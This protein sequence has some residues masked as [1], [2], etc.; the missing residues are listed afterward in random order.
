MKSSLNVFL[1]NA[2]IHQV[3]IVFKS[4]VN[5][6]SRSHQ[7]KLIK[8]GN[9]QTTPEIISENNYMKYTVHDFSSCQLSGDEYKALSYGLDMLE[10]SKSS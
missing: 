3:N 4:K 9:Q 5:S 8:F 6:I 2:V 1:Y 7:N 10:R